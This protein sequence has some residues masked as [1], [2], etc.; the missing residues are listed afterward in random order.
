MISN[1]IFQTTTTKQSNGQSE[2]IQQI[3][4]KQIIQTNNGGVNGTTSTSNPSS[5]SSNSSTAQFSTENPSNVSA[6]IASH[7]PS[8]T[9]GIEP[10]KAAAV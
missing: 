2:P 8:I 10:A 7:S 6:M 5:Q 1:L 9:S 3:S 4:E